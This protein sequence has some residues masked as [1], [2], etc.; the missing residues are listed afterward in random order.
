MSLVSWLVGAAAFTTLSAYA[1]VVN[2]PV[3]DAHDQVH[4]DLGSDIRCACSHRDLCEDGDTCGGITY[5]PSRGAFPHGC[6]WR[7]VQPSNGTDIYEYWD[8]AEHIWVNKRPSACTIN[9]CLLLIWP[10]LP[11]TSSAS[12]HAMLAGA[13]LLHGVELMTSLPFMIR[14]VYM[15]VN[16]LAACSWTRIMS[17]SLPTVKDGL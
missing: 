7:E 16:P 11:W 8:D 10:A 9:V 2:T 15:K 13:A 6:R 17:S 14:L 1:R 3:S 12:A 5:S 4:A